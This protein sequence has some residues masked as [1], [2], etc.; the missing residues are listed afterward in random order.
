MEKSET[1]GE[2]A[3]ALAKAQGAMV[4]AVKDQANP[5]FKSKYADLASVWDACRKPL[6]DNG[7]SVVQTEEFFFD[8]PDLVCVSTILM[9]ESGE[10]I[11]G[12]LAVKPVKSDPQAVGSAITYLRR[13]SLQSMVGV[14]PEDD[15]GNAA[16]QPSTEKTKNQNA[17]A[18]KSAP[19]K[20]EAKEKKEKP[21]PISLVTSL[22]EIT[23]KD[24]VTNGQPWRRY[25]IKDVEDVWYSTFSDS[26]VRIA[27]A[28][29]DGKHLVKIYYTDDS[30]K[31]TVAAIE[32]LETPKEE[33]SENVE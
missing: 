32:I 3:K 8:N 26:I 23:F 30:K 19:P 27:Q 2:L 10:W 5:F 1:I 16:S 15:D 20:T 28:A 24:G 31:K 6:A 13:Y 22:V 25:G 21:T 11:R 7:L 29:I 18:E 12:I 9:H 33:E 17:N 4:G 14:A